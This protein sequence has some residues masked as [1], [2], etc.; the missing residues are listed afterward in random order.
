M[1]AII[2]ATD[3]QPHLPPLTDGI[4]TPLL[5]VVDRPVMAHA[6]EILARAGYKEVLVSLCN[7]GGPIAAYFGSGKRWGVDIRY[8]TQREG[9]GSAGAMKWA[10]RLL[11]QTFLVLPGDSLV[12]LD[13]EAALAYHRTH[14]GVATVILRE[15]RANGASPS[16]QLAAGN[17]VVGV[18]YGASGAVELVASHAFIFEPGVLRYIPPDCHFDSVRDLIPALLA[19]GEPVF[20]YHMDGYWNPLDSLQSYQTAQHV[21]LYSAYRQ[22]DSLSADAHPTVC[23]R[24]PSLD[25]R[26]IASGIWVGAN[27]SIH[28]SV[29]LAAPV[30]IGANSWIGREVEL[31]PGTVIGSNVVI[32]E[33][34]TVSNS[35]IVSETYVGR[36]VDVDHRVVIE[37]TMIDP[38]T[39]DCMRVTDPFLLSRVGLP[40]GTPSR[41]SRVYNTVLA[42]LI[43]VVLSP[44]I[45]LTWLLACI[46][47]A[48]HPFVRMPRVGQRIETID[49]QELHIFQLVHFRTRKANGKHLLFGR[50]IERWELH[51]L[52]E[53]SNVI[54]GDMALVGVKPLTLEEAQLLGEDWQQKRFDVS[55]GLTGLWYLQPE[56]SNDLDTVLV[57]DVYYVA[58]HSWRGN[59][60]ILA[61]TPARWFRRH[62][63]FDSYVQ[64]GEE[65]RREEAKH[66]A[67]S[68]PVL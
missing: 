18:S 20:G 26:Q 49:G 30:Y 25:A 40:I 2:L 41:I 9:W 17:R 47:S 15:A 8:L 28:P 46:G 34:A 21:V 32:D 42:S 57:A 11:N 35:T 13:V 23:V 7:R 16:M 38:T 22:N 59:L 43:L 3:E 55:A 65:A 66:S 48:G 61:K 62:T 53:L 39:G 33:E 50:L 4:P 24:F 44:V 19:A 68:Q 60:S 52:S 63:F 5:P 29:K 67:S 27:A 14:G 37:A 12:D 1:Q 45:A 54:R 51:R 64:G 56:S 10:A 36:L 31:E 58:T 6:V